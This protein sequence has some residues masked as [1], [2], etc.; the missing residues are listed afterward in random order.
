M[1]NPIGRAE[2]SPRLPLTE[3]DPVGYPVGAMTSPLGPRQQ[4]AWAATISV[5]NG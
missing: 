2:A 3:L 4:D 5:R 1:V